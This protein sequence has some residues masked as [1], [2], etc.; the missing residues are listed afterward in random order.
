MAI[1]DRLEQALEDTPDEH[2]RDGETV[3]VVRSDA[4]LQCSGITEFSDSLRCGMA[5][6][7][8]VCIVDLYNVSVPS[9]S[10]KDIDFTL[11]L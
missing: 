9:K 8:Q 10:P 4:L 1:Q 3:L 5:V 11:D 7:R 6:G 2:F